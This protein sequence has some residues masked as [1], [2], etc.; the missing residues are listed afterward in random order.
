MVSN[1]LSL[2]ALVCVAFLYLHVFRNGGSISQF[3]FFSLDEMND[4][5]LVRYMLLSYER[6]LFGVDTKFDFPNIFGKF[7]DEGKQV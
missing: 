3:P 1:F 2:G 7:I 5:K 4:G 6:Q